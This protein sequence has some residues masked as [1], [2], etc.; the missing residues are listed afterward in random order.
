[1]KGQAIPVNNWMAI[2]EPI[3]T[4]SVGNYDHVNNVR[5]MLK[6]VTDRLKQLAALCQETSHQWERSTS[7]LPQCT[8]R[9]GSEGGR[10]CSG[11]LQLA[12]FLQSGEEQARNITV[13]QNLRSCI[14]RLL[15]TRVINT[16]GGPQMTVAEALC[17]K[18]EEVDAN[19]NRSQY[20]QRYC[21]AIRV[22]KKEAVDRSQLSKIAM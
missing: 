12:D 22:V 3:V 10:R 2:L 20:R 5:M 17:L 14:K 9:L 13:N 21:G 15:V 4:V 8:D 18:F 11:C 16:G 1:M 6:Q 19:T 7:L